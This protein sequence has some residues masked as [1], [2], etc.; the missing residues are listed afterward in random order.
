M[1]DRFSEKAIQRYLLLVYLLFLAFLIIFPMATIF[2]HALSDRQGNFILLGN[3]IEYFR[4]PHLFRSLI[5]S[6]VISATTTIISVLLAFIYAYAVFH[7]T[8]RFGYFFRYMALVPLFATTMM[9][10]ISLIYLFG[11]QGF[12]TRMLPEKMFAWF[13]VTLVLD[14]PIYGPLGIIIA[15]VMYTFPQAVMILAVAFTLSDNRLYE[16]ADSLGATTLRKF[17]SITV[18]SV[19]YGILSAVIVVFILS[20]TDIGAPKIIGGQYS[21][22]AV[23]IYKQVVGQ[24]NLPM[25]ATVGI[26][27]LIPS[28][29]AFVAD[30]I[31]QRKK[32]MTFG[33]R[34]VPFVPKKDP[35][36]D[37]VL[38]AYCLMI[39]FA[40]TV[41]I[42]TS[43][44]ASLIKLWP[45]NL[46]LTL[47]HYSFK[48]VSGGIESYI[49]SV[50]IALL[51]A[52]SGV[53]VIF[54]GAYMAEKFRVL[55]HLRSWVSFLAI[56]PLAIPGLIVGLAYVFF[57]NAPDFQLFGTVISNPLNALYGTFTIIVL[58]NIVHFFSV[59]FLTAVTGLKKLDSEYESVSESLAV[60]MHKT[61]FRVT[62]PLS[63][64][65]L[66]EIFF[67]LFVNAMVTVSAVVFL[68]TAET[69]PAAVAII[70]MEEAGDVAAAT[71]LAVLIFVTNMV[72]KFAFDGVMAL[73]RKKSDK[74]LGGQ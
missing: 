45:Y 49:N 29:I 19:R 30:R 42:G 5:N 37:R 53:F 7:R 28:V 31:I 66:M 39:V 9:H 34:S 21:V 16:A 11:N 4:T 17:W 8:I 6:L 60:P 58:A 72:F 35:L 57:F 12:V 13:G 74:W 48:Y 71:A 46:A 23:D 41:M 68:Y 10:G 50:Y 20:F 61:F 40:I 27:L 2:Q 52:I 14:I 36:V 63:L 62:L 59:P 44:I 3:F 54:S 22:L 33:A 47:D 69:R 1:S 18:P 15:E 24:H 26:I 67:Y 25:G 70:N 56:L 51:T 43:I 32:S 55:Q 64:T 38:L 65:S 73:V